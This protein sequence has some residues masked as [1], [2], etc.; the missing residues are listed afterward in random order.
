MNSQLLT[1]KDKKF[2]TKTNCSQPA[3]VERALTWTQHNVKLQSV[4][5]GISNCYCTAWTSAQDSSLRAAEVYTF[6]SETV[7]SDQLQC[8]LQV[9][10]ISKQIAEYTHQSNLKSLDK[11]WVIKLNTSV[12]MHSISHRSLIL[13]QSLH[14]ATLISKFTRDNILKHTLPNYLAR[15]KCLTLSWGSAAQLYGHLESVSL[16]VSP[17]SSKPQKKAFPKQMK[18]DNWAAAHTQQRG[19]YCMCHLPE[20]A[21]EESTPPGA[22]E[23]CF[24]AEKRKR[25][26]AGLCP[27]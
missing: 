16:I 19:R 27:T 8:I 6:W 23:P 11:V 10:Y 4:S 1:D 24:G 22:G 17:T 13:Q 12:S 26:W 3:S 20:Q 9:K 7:V 25:T 15:R 14:S 21:V 18:E 2:W 5:R